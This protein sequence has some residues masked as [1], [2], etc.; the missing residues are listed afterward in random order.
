MSVAAQKVTDREQRFDWPLCYE[1]ENWV[2]EQLDSFCRHN[3]FARA[4]SQRMR[5]ETGT[6]LLDWVDHLVVSP[7]HESAA[8]ALG[9]TD[10]PFTDR[11]LWH[12][13]A[14]LPRVLIGP[15]PVVAI[16]VDSVSDFAVVHGLKSEPEGGPLSAFRRMVA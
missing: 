2:L 7:E 8:R 13:E 10:D 15:Q 1:A 14:M 6:L 3:S 4:L 16:R 12:P 9:F 5:D 11:A